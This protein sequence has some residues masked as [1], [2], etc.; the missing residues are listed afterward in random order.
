MEVRN[1]KDVRKVRPI[2]SIVLREGMYVYIRIY[3]VETLRH[4]TERHGPLETV[5]DR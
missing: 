4:E 5:R 3:P 2:N 1:V